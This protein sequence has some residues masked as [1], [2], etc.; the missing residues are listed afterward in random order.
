MT[1]AISRDTSDPYWDDP[2]AEKTA[3]RRLQSLRDA[4]EAYW[5]AKYEHEREKALWEKE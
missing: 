3:H 4:Q 2:E 5:E 1:D